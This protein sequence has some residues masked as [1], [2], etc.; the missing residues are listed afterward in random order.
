MTATLLLLGALAAAGWYVHGSLGAR[1]AVL[2]HARRACGE[3]GVQLLD[4]T[5]A[6]IR[7]RLA[8]DEHG[9]VRLRRWYRFEYSAAGLDRRVGHATALGARV[10][11]LIIDGDDGATHITGGNVV[12]LRRH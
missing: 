7:S 9:R 8:R 3:L 6:V 5:V 12:P 4:E 11:T 2:A 1:E 10:E